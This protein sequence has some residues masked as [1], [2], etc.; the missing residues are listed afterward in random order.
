MRT[1]DRAMVQ[2]GDELPANYR[3]TILGSHTF[4]DGLAKGDSRMLDRDRVVES[5]SQGS[6]SR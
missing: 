6:F 1:T 4:S 3:G 2:N 5:G